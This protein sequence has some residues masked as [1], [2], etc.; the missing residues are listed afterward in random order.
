[1]C[2]NLLLKYQVGATLGLSFLIKSHEH[3]GILG[4]FVSL[5]GW[6]FQEGVW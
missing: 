6:R 4:I 2:R 1:M 5:R 3:V